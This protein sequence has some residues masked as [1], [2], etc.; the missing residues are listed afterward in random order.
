VG[1]YM[2]ATKI[3]SGM[4]T[5]AAITTAKVNDSAITTA[6]IN[7]AAITAEKIATGVIQSYS[8]VRQTVQ[9]GPTIA[10]G[11]PNFFPS[12][13]ASLAI[14]SNSLATEPLVVSASQGFGGA[15][16]RVGI[17]ST[18]LT[19]SALT[20]SVVNYLYVDVAANGTLTTGSTVTAPVYSL[21][22]TSGTN[23]FSIST[24]TM[25]SSGTTKAWRVFVG[26]CLAGVGTIIS[27]TEYGY[28]GI[29]TNELAAIS[30][31][32]LLAQ[33]IFHNL[34]VV[35][36]KAV[37]MAECLTLDMTIPVGT[38]VVPNFAGVAQTMSLTRNTAI[39]RCVTSYNVHHPSTGVSTAMTVGSWKSW[40]VVERGW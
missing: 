2:S 14:T 18:T 31:L 28:N 24:M 1:E 37:L 13:T 23:T 20:P 21:Y 17:C 6:K 19:W 10:G 33:T 5:D 39:F 35:P 11:L 9:G 7:D 27:T 36:R 30:P 40:L 16:E 8:S 4:I 34:G 12:T 38:V 15:A 22:A 3:T 25:Y 29:Y 26:E 32:S